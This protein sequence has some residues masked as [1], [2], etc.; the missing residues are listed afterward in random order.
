[1]VLYI[2]LPTL[3]GLHSLK[4]DNALNL[5]LEQWSRLVVRERVA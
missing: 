4:S 3:A 2:A 5:S 1:M